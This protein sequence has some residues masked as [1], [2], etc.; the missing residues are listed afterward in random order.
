MFQTVHEAYMFNV[1]FLLH[2]INPRICWAL[3]DSPDAACITKEKQDMFVAVFKGAYEMN[4]CDF[5]PLCVVHPSH[6]AP[7]QLM[8][9]QVHRKA[10]N[11]AL[12]LGEMYSLLPTRAISCTC[13]HPPATTRSP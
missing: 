1:R 8:H 12:M 6:D 4:S 13:C 2:I 11:T 3:K 5:A 10:V 9:L 7:P